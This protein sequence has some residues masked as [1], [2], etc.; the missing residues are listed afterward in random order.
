[1]TD[2][3]TLAPTDAEILDAAEDFRSQ[4]TRGG[5][6]FDVFDE[7][8]YTRAVLAK[9]GAPAPASQP[10]A[11]EFSRSNGDGTHSEHIE[12]GCLQEVAPGRWEHSGLPRGA[13]A[14]KPIKALYTTPQTQPAAVPAGMEPVAHVSQET[15]NDDGTSDIIIPAL[16]IGMALYAAPQPAAQDAPSNGA[17]AAPAQVVPAPGVEAVSERELKQFL[18]DVLTAAGLVTHGK[19]CKDL[20]RRLGEMSMRLRTAPKT[21]AV[22]AQAGEYPPSSADMVMAALDTE[23]WGLER[24]QRCD[25][26]SDEGNREG[27]WLVK[28]QKAPYCACYTDKP[29]APYGP[30]SWSGPTALDA[31]QKAAD[32]LGIRL[33]QPAARG[34]TQASPV[35]ANVQAAVPAD[36]MTFTSSTQPALQQA[37]HEE[38]P[39]GTTIPIDP[40]EMAPQQPAPAPMSPANRLVAYSAATRLRE[41]GFEWDATAEAWLQPASKEKSNDR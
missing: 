38:Q 4:Y 26:I 13:L 34:A 28:R 30:R 31:L 25:Y 40:S 6:T 10:Y 5:P 3:N 7:I 22:P 9:W 14:D 15:F 23:E 39:D 18:T 27:A 20:G 41:L 35:D 17:L 8:G 36:L 12:R 16:P 21:A 11:Y 32:D 33:P 1:M 37:H 19:K 24:I 2:T 29:G